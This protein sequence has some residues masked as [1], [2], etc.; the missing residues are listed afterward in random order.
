MPLDC[1]QS[2]CVIELGFKKIEYGNKLC[3]TKIANAL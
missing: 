1:E 2:R 3:N